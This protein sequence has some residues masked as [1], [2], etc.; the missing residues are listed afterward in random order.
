[1][2]ISYLPIIFMSALSTT[3]P[4]H[5]LIQD[6]LTSNQDSPE[7]AIVAASIDEIAQNTVY[8]CSVVCSC[9]G[10][11]V[12]NNIMPCERHDWPCI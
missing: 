3:T 9:T 10:M 6:I 4:E 7:G 11:H 2:L 8:T 12:C 5:L 1:M